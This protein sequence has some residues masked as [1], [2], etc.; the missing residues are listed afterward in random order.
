MIFS[1]YLR[2]NLN[3]KINNFQ[4]FYSEHTQIILTKIT[5]IDII[6]SL[7]IQC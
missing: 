2:I 4:F 1:K 6:I 5:Y 7:Q 3:A